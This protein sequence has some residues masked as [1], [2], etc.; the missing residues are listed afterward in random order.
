MSKAQRVLLAL[1]L[2]AGFG[3]LFRAIE[4]H[5]HMVASGEPF[6]VSQGA[7]QSVLIFETIALFALLQ[8]FLVWRR[9]HAGYWPRKA[10]TW[11]LACGSAF[12]LVMGGPVYEPW[13]SSSSIALLFIASIWYAA[14]P[15]DSITPNSALVPDASERRSRASFN[16]A[17]RER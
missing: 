5:W 14:A 13:Y 7:E 11:V 1:W 16:A 9:S 17:Q 3:I 2:V 6:N 12:W 4:A 15:R 10:V 8:G